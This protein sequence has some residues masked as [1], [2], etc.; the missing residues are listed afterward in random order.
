MYGECDHFHKMLS[1]MDSMGLNSEGGKYVDTK[2][3]GHLGSHDP[4]KSP[5]VVKVRRDASDR[6][7][8]RA[9]AAR[10]C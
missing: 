4:R 8:R 10:A 5:D 6:A 1:V 9:R 2:Y 7:A 3:G